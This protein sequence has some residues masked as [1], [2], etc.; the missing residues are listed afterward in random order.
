MTED[1]KKEFVYI[2]LKDLY[3]EFNNLV[4]HLEVLREYYHDLLDVKD[5]KEPI[6]ETPSV[7]Q[8][9]DRQ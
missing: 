7:L 1:E 8:L 3:H 2:T 6:Y 4:N 9:G 5:G